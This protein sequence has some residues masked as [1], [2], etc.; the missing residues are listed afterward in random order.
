MKNFD[1]LETELPPAPK[2][3]F[4]TSGMEERIGIPALRAWIVAV[5]C[6]ALAGLLIGAFGLKINLWYAIPIVSI[7]VFLIIFW[8]STQRGQALVERLTGTDLNGDGVIGSVPIQ[9]PL[10]PV[11]IELVEDQGKHTTYADLPFPDRLPSLAAGLLA[12][13][14][15]AQ[16]A[17][18]GHLGIFSRA[19]FDQLRDEMV[20]RGL[21]AWKN[22]SAKA[23]GCEL[24]AA[25]RAVMRR[26]APPFPTR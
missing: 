22:E 26:L 25:G 1:L 23:Q 18:T 6:G 10:P 12:G 4:Q 9:E 20:R 16:S 24:T 7:T 21:A 17:W 14:Q 13:R 5:P 11:R 3:G 8:T 19:E 2:V 15:F